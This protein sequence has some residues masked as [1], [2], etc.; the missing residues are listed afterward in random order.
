[1]YPR[2]RNS[3]GSDLTRIEFSS[4]LGAVYEDVE[5][6]PSR[7]WNCLRLFCCCCCGS[8]LVVTD[9]STSDIN[10]THFEHHHRLYS[11]LLFVLRDVEVLRP[12][13]LRDIRLE[14]RGTY[15]VVLSGCIPEI[16]PNRGFQRWLRLHANSF[17]LKSSTLSLQ[18]VSTEMLSP[19]P[20]QN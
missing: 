16:S 10:N 9:Q 3:S 6:K 5:A 14:R 15:E 18:K 1:M 17:W 4:I 12:A 13:H 2:F 8:G 7:G 20:E 11:L 19:S